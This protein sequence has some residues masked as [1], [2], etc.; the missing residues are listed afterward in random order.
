[1]TSACLG[2]WVGKRYIQ[3]QIRCDLVEYISKVQGM[4]KSH[5]EVNDQT[6][7]KVSRIIKSMQFETVEVALQRV[8]SDMTTQALR[9]AQKAKDVLVKELIRSGASDE[10]IDKALE[11]AN[12]DA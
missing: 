5:K 11:E 8:G 7:A 4:L 9:Q 1:M 12:Q 10:Q 6:W 2:F 3:E